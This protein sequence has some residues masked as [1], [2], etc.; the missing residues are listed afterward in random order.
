MWLLVLAGIGLLARALSSE[1]DGDGG[2]QST[3]RM[4]YYRTRDGRADYG[5][6]IERQS[7]GT[8]RPYVASQ[9]NYGSSSTGDHETHRLTGSGGRK[10]VCW[11]RPLH[12][13]EEAK[14]VAALWA[15]ATQ[16]YIRTGQRF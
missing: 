16:N 4:I 7:G 8:Y 13:E 10:Y 14:T 5:F 11:D 15:D 9:P 3:S 6:S 1:N 12:S 2:Q